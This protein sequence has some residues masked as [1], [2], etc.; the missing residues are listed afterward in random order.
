MNTMQ[1]VLLL[2]NWLIVVAIIGILVAI[3]IP[4]IKIIS[5]SYSGFWKV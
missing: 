3:A 5:L 2:S 1:K 4:D